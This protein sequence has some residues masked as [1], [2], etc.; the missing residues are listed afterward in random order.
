MSKQ[1]DDMDT[2]RAL[3]MASELR[4]TIGKLRRLLR[5]QVH[6]G[7]LTWS[8]VTVL[9]RLER[10]GPATVT[11]LARAEGVRSQSMGA[12]VAALV[13]AELIVGSPHPKDGRQ[14]ILTLTDACRTLVTENR[15]VRD[16]WLLHAIQAKLTIQEQAQLAQGIALLK[17]LAND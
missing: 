1:P 3:E 4:I 14:T 16:D 5:E 2:E 11:E 6:I 13:S 12:T 7:N 9:G 17:R 10:D 15:A 8:E